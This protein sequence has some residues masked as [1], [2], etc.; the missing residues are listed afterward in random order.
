MIYAVGT[1]SSGRSGE[2]PDGT[3]AGSDT[4]VEYI[5]DANDDPSIKAVVLRVDSPGGSS[6][7]SD[8]IWRELM[9]LRE[10]KPLD[11]L[12]VGPRGVGRLL[13]RDGR[14]RTSSPSPAR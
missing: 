7:A 10:E 1:I 9:L 13:H 2:G 4:L 12:D 6:V 5:Q 14:P 3:Y 11:R 8:V